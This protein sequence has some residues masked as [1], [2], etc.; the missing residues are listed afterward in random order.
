MNI[1]YLQ[2]DR[3]RKSIAAGRWSNV[4]VKIIG[5]VHNGQTK[6]SNPT[7]STFLRMWKENVQD[8]CWKTLWKIALGIDS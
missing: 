8:F 5:S 2:I 1:E 6:N 4:P 7:A 3:G